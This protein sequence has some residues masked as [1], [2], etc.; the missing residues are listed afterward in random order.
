MTRTL[1]RRGLLGIAAAGAFAADQRNE[2]DFPVVDF[3]AHITAA[4]TLERLFAIA[5]TRGVR[6]GVV[7]HAGDAKQHRY[8][9]IIANDS[10]LN[11]YV[12]KLNPWPCYKG[13]QAEGVDWARCFSRQALARLDYVLTDALTLVD[14]DGSLVRLW[15][16]AAAKFK[17]K[18]DFMERYTAFHVKVLEAGPA[19]ILANPLFLPEHFQPEADALWTEERMQ[20]IVRAAVKQ[21]VAL[22]IN[23]RFR[24]PS[25]KFLKMA[26]GAGAKFSFGSNILGDG[27]GDVRWSCEVAKQLGL[28]A[29]HLFRPAYAG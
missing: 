23:S 16:P 19:N 22:E 7:E 9:G 27:V 14:S 2:F 4:P 11:A 13:I 3:H 1:S 18:Q 5:K 25:L 8:R 21:K 17:H 24:L 15:T 10:D 26:K 29:R 12:E 28:M 20:R 6:F